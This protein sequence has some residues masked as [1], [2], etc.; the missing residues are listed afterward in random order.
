MKFKE[1]INE[2]IMGRFDK[3]SLATA[4][5]IIDIIKSTKIE[6]N[7]VLYRGFSG[8]TEGLALITN[9]REA[10]Y[11][12]LNKEAFKFVKEYL[13]VKN[14][15]F[16]TTDYTQASMFGSVKIFI[17][18]KNDTLLYSDKVNDVMADIGFDGRDENHFENLLSSY[19]KATIKNISKHKGEVIV[20]TKEYY[21]VDYLVTANSFKSK[22]FE[23]KKTIEGLTYGDVV[24]MLKSYISY[25]KFLIKVGKQQPFDVMKKEMDD[26]RNKME[27]LRKNRMSDESKKIRFKVLLNFLDKEGIEYTK[28]E[29]DRSVSFKTQV[30][31]KKVLKM[32]DKEN[33]KP[34]MAAKLRDMTQVDYLGAYRD[35]KDKKKIHSF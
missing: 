30:L 1:Y 24:E 13:K 28:D 33:E 27:K 7:K 2:K 35:N 9:D 32:I 31:L 14:P 16:A 29:D 3:D 4:Q 15:T 5:E 20:D 6:K 34:N 10:F 17:P 11:G 12:A 22:F 25:N 21:L 8:M 23:P 19:N 18:N 26:N